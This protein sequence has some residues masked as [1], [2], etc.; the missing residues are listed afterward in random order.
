MAD[1]KQILEI[2]GQDTREARAAARKERQDAADKKRKRP[3][4]VNREIFAL[5]N[6]QDPQMLPNAN[7]LSQEAEPGKPTKRPKLDRPVDEWV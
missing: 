5:L 6:D 3:D 7:E 4:N 1:V 2:N